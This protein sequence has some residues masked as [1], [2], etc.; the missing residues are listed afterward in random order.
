M[1][2][3]RPHLRQISITTELLK[4]RELTYLA[5]FDPPKDCLCVI[6]HDDISAVQNIRDAEN[7]TRW[8]IFPEAMIMSCCSFL[9]QICFLAKNEWRH[10]YGRKSTG[11]SEMKFA[12]FRS[13]I[14]MKF[15]IVCRVDLWLKCIVI[16]VK[17]LYTIF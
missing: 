5:Y 13:W 15:L 1:T 4:F 14:H 3:P 12:F 10:S 11:K 7:A 17:I 6:R 16:F 8:S 9:L 2:L